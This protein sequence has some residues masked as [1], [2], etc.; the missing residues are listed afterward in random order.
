MARIGRR[1]VAA[2]QQDTRSRT[3]NVGLRAGAANPPNALDAAACKLHLFYV[4]FMDDI[5]VLAPTR[6]LLRGAV[7]AVNQMLGALEKHQDKT[8][9]GRIERGFD[10]LGYH[11]SPAGLSVAKQ[12]VGNFI[13]KASRL[14]SRSGGRRQPPPPLEMYV[15]RWLR[16]FHGWG[17]CGK[18]DDPV[19]LVPPVRHHEPTARTLHVA[20]ARSAAPR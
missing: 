16:W 13:E 19:Q 8:F 2:P 6:W 3:S 1:G 9:I 5:L 4:R 17:P 7:K 11:F 15:R 12:T 10:F 20:W 18:A 14:M